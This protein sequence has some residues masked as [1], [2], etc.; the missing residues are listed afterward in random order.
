[1]FVSL[2]VCVCVCVCV[3]GNSPCLCFIC[4][5]VHE[6]MCH[7]H[8]LC[9]WLRLHGSVHACVRVCPCWSL[10]SLPA[11]LINGGV[12][13]LV[14]VTC[15]F[16]I[17][18]A[19]TRLQNQQ[20]VKVYKGMWVGLP[21]PELTCNRPRSATYEDEGFPLQQFV[22]LAFLNIFILLVVSEKA[23]NLQKRLQKNIFFCKCMQNSLNH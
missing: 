7:W 20:D 23:L 10:C 15:V 13:G 19:K 14:G 2:C 12:A 21:W 3:W 16:P 5:F 4:V 1:M 8:G 17:D 22:A 18:L 9:W 11:K 6:W